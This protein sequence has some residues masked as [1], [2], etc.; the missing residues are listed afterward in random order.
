MSKNILVLSSSPRKGGNSDIL[1]DQFIKGAQESGHKTEKIYVAEMKINFCTGCGVCHST[2]KC[3]HKDDMEE[4]FEKLLNADVI[5]F[6]SPVYFYSMC[7][8]LKVFIDRLVPV[9]TKLIGKEVYIFVTAWD[10]QTSNLESTVESIRGLTRDCMEETIE[11]GVIYGGGA[12]EKGDVKSTSA[13]EQAYKF[14]KE[15]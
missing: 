9:Y 6:S 2:G 1:C 8:Q 12:A 7:A 13:Y 14:G 10:S 15:V 11:R 5:V 4:V 3:V